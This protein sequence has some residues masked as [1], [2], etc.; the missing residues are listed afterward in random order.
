MRLSGFLLVLAMFLL[1]SG[2][3]NGSPTTPPGKTGLVDVTPPW[4]NTPLDCMDISDDLLFTA[5]S[6]FGLHISDTSKGPEPVWINKVDLPGGAREILVREGFAYLLAFCELTIVDVSPVSSAHVVG[7]V[8][9]MRNAY[10]AAIEGDYVYLVSYTEEILQIISVRDP[11]NPVVVRSLDVPNTL[12]DV[13]VKGKYVYAAGPEN[14]L[15][16][17]D[18][19]DPQTASVVHSVDFEG[20]CSTIVTS[21]DVVLV[22]DYAKQ[23]HIV[24]V[25]QPLEATIVE[26]FELAENA[27]EIFIKDEYAFVFELYSGSG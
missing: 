12:F 10:D 27:E 23:L 6:R 22:G 18:V 15:F 3:S 9:T 16:V 14:G 13:V 8:E 21:G 25:S 7:T 2:C 17:I 26:S 24:D 5:G 20:S 19:S 4:L 1:F 11:E